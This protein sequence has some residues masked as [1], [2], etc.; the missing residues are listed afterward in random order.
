MTSYPSLRVRRSLNELQ[1]EHAKG[2]TKPL[3]DLMRAWR[4]IKELPPD[5]PNSFFALGGLHGEPFR[6]AGW[7]SSQ[8]WGGYCNHGNILF[9]TWHRMYV[10]KLEEA[11]QSIKDC[12]HVM[13]AFWDEARPEDSEEPVIPWALTD[14][15]YK[16]GKDEEIPNPL[17]SF[18][19]NR[20]ITDFIG[21]DIVNYSK[22]KGYETVRYP[23]SGLVGTEDDRA[24]TKA[25]NA[26][27][28]DYEKNVKI[29]NA[30]VAAWLN[31]EIVVKGKPI[32]TG[33]RKK[34]RE[35]LDAPT[36]TLFS[37]TSS[38]RQWNNDHDPKPP[39]V[40]L[41]SPHNSVHL[42]VGGFDGPGFDRSPISG[43]NGDMGENDTA[44]LDPIFFFHHCFIDRVFW[45]WQKKQGFTDHLE[46]DDGYVGTNS[47]DGQG[48]T[49]G[50]PPNSWLTLDSPLNPWKGEDGTP[51]TSR[52]CLNIE[53][54]LGYTY[55]PGSLDEL[56]EPRV[57][58]AAADEDGSQK[59]I[60]VT[61][62][63]R[64]AIRG[65]F[66]IAAYA[67]I[68]GERHQVGHEAVLSRWNVEGC[69]NCQAHI[70]AR[71]FVGLTAFPAET[72]AD[73]TFTVEVRTRDEVMV[74][75][76]LAP[77]E[78]DAAGEGKVRRLRASAGPSGAKTFRV[79]IR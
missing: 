10:L 77:G 39:I 4:G 3:D 49:P 45:L 57:T 38:A 58:A 61:G 73:A 34:Y 37:N 66:L 27:Y 30:N 68:D 7:G 54:Q 29:L 60:K 51:P 63:N 13:M 36:Y 28:P 78:A 33:V 76:E 46:V 5:N 42:A 53:T 24:K 14:K 65:S 2:N 35:C 55:G 69:A 21:N 25:H 41:E 31:A 19:F 6:G 47:V 12:G 70:E 16:L 11:L 64:A 50:V 74:S 56:V 22:A 40:P 62:L 1:D 20:A 79:E 32:E 23:L 71:A 44:G 18:V 43:A 72:L 52:D 67:T 15:M 9:P 75:D 8:Y 17:R 59:T 48:A 26:K